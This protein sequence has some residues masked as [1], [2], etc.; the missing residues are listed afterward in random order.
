[1]AALLTSQHPL[2]SQRRDTVPYMVVPRKASFDGVKFQRAF[3]LT[4]GLFVQDCLPT[5][6]DGNREQGSYLMVGLIAQGTV[7]N[8]PAPV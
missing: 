1:M 4:F 8:A 5:G 7:R 2:R 3:S 6:P